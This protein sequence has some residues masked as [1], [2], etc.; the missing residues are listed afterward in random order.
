MGF[1]IA[2][3][4]RLA[5][6]GYVMAREGVFSLVPPIDLPPAARFALRAGRA[7]ERPGARGSQDDA[8]LTEA[9]NR[10]GP[11]YVKLGQFLATRPDVVGQ[12]AANELAKLQ[13]RVPPV[14]DAMIRAAVEEGLGAPI[15]SLFVSF[16]PAVAAASIAQ[17]HRA[18]V[19][20]PDGTEREVAVKVLKPGVATRF[21]RDLESYYVAARMVE[22]FLPVTRRLRPLA[23][24]DTLARS[25]TLE[26]DLRLEAAALSEMAEN[27]AE[28]EGFRVPS[29]DWRRTAKTV[30]TMEWI[31]GIK[32]SDA[33]R[34]DA[35]GIDRPKLAT[36]IMQSF[37]RHAVRDGFFHADMHQ[38]NLLVEPNGTL[39]ALDLGIMG[40][41]NDAERR[42]LAEIL[43][44]FIRRDYRRVAEVHFEAGYVP[45]GQDVDVFAQALRAI[46]EPIR[47]H[48]AQEIS[49]ARLLTQLFE[50]TELFA[51]YT[52][53]RLIMLQKTMVVVEGV[54]RSVDPDL[55]MWRTAEPVVGDWIARRLGPAGR[56]ESAGSG[57]GA[58]IK[59]VSDLPTL[60][61]RAERISASLADMSEKGVVLEDRSLEALAA[62][63]SRRGRSGRLALWVGA[64]SLLA[65]ALKVV[66]GS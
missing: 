47:G 43:Y 13:D 58:L 6:A 40:R 59:L 10:L 44:G 61:E 36:T 5:R 7:F 1:A 14:D 57:F 48:T 8:R 60:A 29:V 62:A 56:L 18:T 31:D 54:A 11:S 21:A 51:M 30:L 32:L 19:R 12:D 23:I 37:L 15:D 20:D 9:F 46:G 53:P 41:L 49:M 22:R 38:G 2:P 17:V 66:F 25:V 34:I 24:V 55:D 64:L 3:L 4:Y 27:T 35:A 39:V 33:E 52:Q 42:F 50:V 16:G 45:R 28:D 65:I 26:M 63:E